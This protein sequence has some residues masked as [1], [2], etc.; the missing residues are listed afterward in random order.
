MCTYCSLV[1]K[2]KRLKEDSFRN[3]LFTIGYNLSD[4]ETSIMIILSLRAKYFFSF[5]CKWGSKYLNGIWTSFPVDSSESRSWKNTWDVFKGGNDLDRKPIWEACDLLRTVTLGSTLTLNFSQQ[6]IHRKLYR[7]LKIYLFG[8]FFCFLFFVFL[9]WKNNLL[10][11]YPLMK[12]MCLI[13]ISFPGFWCVWYVWTYFCPWQPSH[14]KL[15][16]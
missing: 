10:T 3:F 12:T 7:L 5:G 16:F 6:L 2:N 14:I 1:W 9:T 4:H 15:I 13:Q 11:A 8:Q